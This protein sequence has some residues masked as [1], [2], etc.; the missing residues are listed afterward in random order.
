MLISD[1]D[2]ASN[3]KRL[4]RAKKFWD[5]QL[6]EL[7]KLNAGY[8]DFL[9]ECKTER[10][11]IRRAVSMAEAAGYRNLKDVIAEGGSLKADEEQID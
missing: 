1:L 6:D 5:E 11:C 7:E 3:E 8:I 9:S 2:K 4:A 10:E